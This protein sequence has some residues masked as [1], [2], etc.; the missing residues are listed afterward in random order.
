MRRYLLS[1]AALALLLCAGCGE[2][3]GD[4]LEGVP[5]SE[6][7][8]I[9]LP[10]DSSSSSALTAENG[11]AL[12]N[13]Q[14]GGTAEFYLFTR[15]MTREVNGGVY[16]L[17]LMIEDIAHQTPTTKEDDRWI[18][19]P[20]TPALDPATYKVTIEKRSDADY[21]WLME[22]KPKDQ[23]DEAY[24]SLISG[25]HTRGARPRRGQGT[26]T[27]D[28]DNMASI[29]ATKVERGSAEVTY[30]SDIYPVTVTVHFIDF[31]GEDGKGPTDA[32]YHYTE[33]EDTS[34]EFSFS[35]NQDMDLLGEPE[36]G[37]IL[38]RWVADGRGRSDI[39]LSGGDLLDNEPPISEVVAIECWDT[40]FKRTYFKDWATTSAGTF[41]L[42]P[43][44]G[45]ESD[46]VYTDQRLPE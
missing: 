9:K 46:C 36:D 37:K 27:L 45:V 4:F 40:M 21:A 6:S 25:T 10:G 38:S 3:D 17:L 22:A 18:W 35:T 11:E 33:N 29:D 7:I 12:S 32:Q 31:T 42:D 19:G 15:Q 34:G 26:I 44:Q 5:D 13:T 41:E 1:I 23:G 28:F 2:E 16:Y 8:R 39:R 24:L 43:E 14:L 20:Y 30:Q